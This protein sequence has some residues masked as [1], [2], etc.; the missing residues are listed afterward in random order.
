MTEE[1]DVET[2]INT[3]LSNRTAEELDRER[4]Y[5]EE[6]R[7]RLT[8][9]DTRTSHAQRA[10]DIAL[11]NLESNPDDDFE[12]TRMAEGY[13]LLGDFQKAAEL[14]RNEEKRAEYQAYADA[15]PIQCVCSPVRQGN[16]TLA[17]RFVKEKFPGKDL[18]YCTTC[19]EYFYVEKA[20]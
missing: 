12:Y 13:Y 8:V 18:I 6:Q 2:A 11:H 7:Q 3:R 9:M 5:Q 15:K 17:P 20:R 10:I 1:F 19:R 4:R 14:T 16:V